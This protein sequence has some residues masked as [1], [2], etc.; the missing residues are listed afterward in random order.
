M[1]RHTQP[2]RFDGG[3]RTIGPG[4]DLLHVH[5]H[6]ESAAH[7]D[8]A[9]TWDTFTRTW[10]W[11]APLPTARPAVEPGAGPVARPVDGGFSLSGR[12][13]LRVHPHPVWFVLPLATPGDT[14][15]E[16][17]WDLFVLPGGERLPFGPSGNRPTGALELT[18]AYVP[19]GLATRRSGVPLRATDEIFVG[20]AVTAMALGATRRLTDVLARLADGNRSAALPAAELAALTHDEQAALRSTLYGLRGACE[21][22]ARATGPLTRAV[23]VAR[24]VVAGAYE[25]A[26]AFVSPDGRHPLAY[27]IEAATPILQVTRFVEDFATRPHPHRAEGP[28]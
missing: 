9:T 16:D 25:G 27:L 10:N 5:D 17:G 12:W 6:F 3:S 20:V 13:H 8:P 7:R 24:R 21:S 15:D 1:T 22:A 11:A 28:A 26:I 4:A 23:N 18:D 14:A 2:T 19:A